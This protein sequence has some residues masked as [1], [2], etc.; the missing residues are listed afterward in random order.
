MVFL[1]RPATVFR[2]VPA[3][4]WREPRAPAAERGGSRTAWR[5]L[6]AGRSSPPPRAEEACG[7]GERGGQGQAGGD[8]AHSHVRTAR[9][10]FARPP[11]PGERAWD[12]AAR[13]GGHRQ[14][15]VASVSER[16]YG[17]GS[18]RGAFNLPLFLLPLSL[19]PWFTE[20]AC[21][22][23]FRSVASLPRAPRHPP[24]PLTLSAG[25]EII[26][27][28]MPRGWLPASRP[29]RGGQARTP[30]PLAA[31]PADGAALLRR[32]RASPPA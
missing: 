4:G 17:T 5:A 31:S 9:V 6:P 16:C 2:A 29:R 14:R 19:S 22:Q 30:A 20:V 26:Q 28:F 18:P 25:R 27:R 13:R 32:C 10:F 1:T 3:G 21:A 11:P 15:R 8:A 12:G 24:P 23:C 7:G